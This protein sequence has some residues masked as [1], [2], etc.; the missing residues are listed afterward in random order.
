M[1]RFEYRQNC[2]YCEE[3][4]VEAIAQSLGTPLYVYSLGT[5]LDHFKRL[6]DAFQEVHPLICYSVKANANAD[7]LR[8]LAKESVGRTWFPQE[9]FIWR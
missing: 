6:R 1:H 2:L 3:V 8:H 5:A 4:P 7:L 9:R